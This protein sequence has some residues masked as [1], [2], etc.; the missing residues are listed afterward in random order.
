MTNV[1]IMGMMGWAPSDGDED[2][3]HDSGGDDEHLISY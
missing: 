1:V 3:D 2:D